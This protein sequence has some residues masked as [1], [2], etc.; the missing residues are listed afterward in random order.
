MEGGGGKLRGVHG[1]HTPAMLRV[2]CHTVNIPDKCRAECNKGTCT[3]SR[4]GRTSL[5]ALE[6][7]DDVRVRRGEEDF[8]LMRAAKRATKRSAT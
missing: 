8:G 7:A 2:G 1:G 5:L 6:V 4:G 3:C